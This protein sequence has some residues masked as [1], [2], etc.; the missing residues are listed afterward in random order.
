M[1]PETDM[2]IEIAEIMEA[3]GDAD[4]NHLARGELLQLQELSVDEVCERAWPAHVGGRCRR[5][6]TSNI[7]A[8]TD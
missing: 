8:M 3:A 7:Y 5:M 2:E 4:G 6:L 1:Q